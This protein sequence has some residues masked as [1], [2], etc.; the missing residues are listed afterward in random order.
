[1]TELKQTTGKE[2][3]MI[4][5]TDKRSLEPHVL[6][7]TGLKAYIQA[8]TPEHP[9]GERRSIQHSPLSPKQRIAIADS[10]LQ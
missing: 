2:R 8:F 10:L 3:S 1:M 4:S 9:E 5:D 6:R 7:G